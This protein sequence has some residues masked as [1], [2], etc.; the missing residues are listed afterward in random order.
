MLR[1]RRALLRRLGAAGGAVVSGLLA[2]CGSRR[3][4][5][6]DV[7][8]VRVGSKPF[9]EQE[10]LGYLAYERLQRLDGVQVVDEI[11]YGDSLENWR[12]V[13]RGTK[14]LY[15]EY[16]GTAWTR[17]PPKH[18]MRVRD[19]DH[20]FDRVRTDARAAGLRM[21]TPASFSNGF[22]LVADSDWANRNGV[23][24]LTDFANHVAQGGTDIGVAVGEDF[25][26]RS[27]LWRGVLN[28]YGVDTE[29]RQKLESEHF[30]VTSIGLT[31]ELLEDG[32]VDVASG[33]ETDPQ[34][35]DSSLVVLDDDR[36]Y[37]IPYV[38]VPTGHAPTIESVPAVFEALS[39]IAATLD[40]AT[41]RRLNRRVLFA[42]ESP[43]AV[44]ASHLEGV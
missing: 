19:P 2:G 30:V 26:H 35:A 42:D 25:F 17:L 22:V 39:P 33:F 9:A 11:G 44:A 20:L 27:N 21:G 5:R 13:T 24:T 43:Q 3:T 7:T 34:L 6:D 15:W 16:T 12:A 40:A 14:H 29:T 4:R 1:T 38:P 8:V 41:M 31:Y 10:I 36:R 32:E 18:S 28:Y 23:R 37:F